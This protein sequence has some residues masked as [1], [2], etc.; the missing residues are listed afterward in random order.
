M[1]EKRRKEEKCEVYERDFNID[2]CQK[3]GSI[4]VVRDFF[5]TSVQKFC[6][7][8]PVKASEIIL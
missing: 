6:H 8:L 3:E 1:V 7:R 2:K 4:V 5:L